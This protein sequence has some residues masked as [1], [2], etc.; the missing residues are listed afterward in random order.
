VSEYPGPPIAPHDPEYQ[1]EI[2]ESSPPPRT[3]PAQDRAALDAQD[4]AARRFTLLIGAVA[5]A[6][7][8]VLILVLA[9]A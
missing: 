1:P 8:A 9:L 4:A 5:A 3:L 7:L 6:T 2:I